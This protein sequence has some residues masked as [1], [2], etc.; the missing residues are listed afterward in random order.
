L[1]P[2]R[3]SF[4]ERDYQE[5]IFLLTQRDSVP[6]DLK[7]T[8]A[9]GDKIRIRGEFRAFKEDEVRVYAGY[10]TNVRI[11]AAIDQFPR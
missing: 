1:F 9:N 11:E 8:L 5:A 3:R 6:P 7:R 4:E 10:L 2:D